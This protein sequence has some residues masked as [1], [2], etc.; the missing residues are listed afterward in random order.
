MSLQ[1]LMIEQPS[2]IFKVQG[3]T[4]EQ[5]WVVTRYGLPSR[6][7]RTLMPVFVVNAQI[8]LQPLRHNSNENNLTVR[9]GSRQT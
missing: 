9:F 8:E 7:R 3:S 4:S 6:F 5:G 2:S 1:I